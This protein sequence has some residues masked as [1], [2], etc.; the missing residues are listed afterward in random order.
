MRD[1]AQKT[2]PVYFALAK[3]DIGPPGKIKCRISSMGS[4]TR[5][6]P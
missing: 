4:S 6:L 5:K 3:R 2:Q 1:F